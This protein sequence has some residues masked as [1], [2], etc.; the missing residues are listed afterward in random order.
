MAEQEDV[1]YNISEFATEDTVAED[2]DQPNKSVLQEV[3]D[4]LQECLDHDKS[5]DSLDL[6]KD[7][8]LTVKQQVFIAKRDN[9]RLSAAKQLIDNKIKELL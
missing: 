5:V 7:A 2:P 9:A 1:P 3:S 6:S 8:T 4:F